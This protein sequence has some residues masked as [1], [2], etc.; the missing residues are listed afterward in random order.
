MH[1]WSPFCYILCQQ[2]LRERAAG[3][4]EYFCLSNATTSH[5]H[6]GIPY[7]WQL[8]CLF[9]SLFR[10]TAK[11][12]QSSVLLVLLLRESITFVTIGFTSQMASN[13]ECV[14]MSW[15]PSF[16]TTMIGFSLSCQCFWYL[17]TIPAPWLLRQMS[18]SK[19]MYLIHCGLVTSF[20]DI[21]LAPSHYLNQSVRSCSTHLR[22]ISQKKCS[23]Y[24]FLIWVWSLQI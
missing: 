24:L 6:H 10:L 18:N 17:T 3:S 15:P 7:H 13:S 12:N 4:S 23:K 19:E 16:S 1:H 11:K 5:E 14:C 21:E 9:N 20:G 22:A 2:G 8:D